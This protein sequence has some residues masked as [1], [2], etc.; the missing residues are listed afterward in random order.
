M[1]LL[2]VFLLLI[3]HAKFASAQIPVTDAANIAQSVFNHVEDLAKFVEQIAKAQEQIDQLKVEYESMTGIRGFGGVA[4]D[5]KFGSYL[6]DAWQGAY[7]S[8]RQGG[9]LGLTA[10]GKT[11]RDSTQVYDACARIANP[12]RRTTCEAQAVMA[13]QDKA[14]TLDSYAL[15]TER[16]TQIDYLRRSIDVT[17]DPKGIAELQARLAAEQAAIENEKTKLQLYRMIAETESRIQQQQ[18]REH[19]AAELAKRGWG[20]YPTVTFE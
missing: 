2:L 17:Q 12:S 1:R 3:S 8:L 19:N 6:P 11:I 9:Y 4:Y 16:L 5:P 18:A 13:S 14:F 7:D 15:A 20:T 10:K